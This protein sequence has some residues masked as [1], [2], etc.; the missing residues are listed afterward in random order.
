MMIEQTRLRHL[1]MRVI[2]KLEKCLQLASYKFNQAFVMP[3]LEYNVRGTKAG[4]AYLQ[5]NAIKLNRTLLLEN[6]T[7]FINQV[8]PH[9]LAHLIVYQ[10]FGNVKPHGKEWKKVMTE[11]F[12]LPAETCHKFD[13]KNVR[14]R[15]FHYRCQCQTHLLTVRRHNKIQAGNVKYFCRQC[16]T[17]IVAC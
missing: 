1:N 14:G 10:V 16:Q 5:Q 9:E 8:V 15:T 2:R 13:I 11:L 17:E 6:P 7:E 4:V 12:H 3:T